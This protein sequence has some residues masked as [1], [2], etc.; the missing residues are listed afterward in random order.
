M[1][2]EWKASA[3]YHEA[4]HVIIARS[5]GITPHYVEINYNSTDRRWEGTTELPELKGA[6]QDKIISQLAICFAGCFSQVKHAIRE[7]DANEPIPWKEIY[8]WMVCRWALE[9]IPLVGAQTIPL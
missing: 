7:L 1:D 5:R 4:G 8:E 6:T 2:D 9:T 3:A